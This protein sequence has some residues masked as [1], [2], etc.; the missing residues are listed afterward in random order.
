MNEIGN[1]VSS[2]EEIIKRERIEGT[3]F[4]A[5]NEGDGWFLVM[6]RFKITEKTENIQ[7]LEEQIKGVN[8]GLLGNVVS[9]IVI[10]T[11]TDM[12]AQS[13]EAE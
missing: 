4:D 1:R 12:V 10:N 9:A 6:G 11:A 7:E 2:N 3:P 8:W 5:I 13:K